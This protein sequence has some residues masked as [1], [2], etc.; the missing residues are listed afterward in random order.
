MRAYCECVREKEMG[1]GEQGVGKKSQRRKG[2]RGAER[3]SVVCVYA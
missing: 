2:A 1:A 3:V